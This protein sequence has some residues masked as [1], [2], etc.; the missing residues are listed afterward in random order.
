[1]GPIGTFYASLPKWVQG[2]LVAVEGGLAGFLVQWITNPEAL[3]WSAS[4]FR[5]FGGVIGG[6]ILMSIRNW[7]KQSPLPREVWSREQRAVVAGEP[8]VFP[9]A[10]PPPDKP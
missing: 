8:N 3:C 10:S 2:L 5:K 6:V 1:M 7:L 9:K 4:C